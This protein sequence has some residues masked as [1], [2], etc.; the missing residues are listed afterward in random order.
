MTAVPTHPTPRVSVLIV[1][2]NSGDWL[3]RCLGALARQTIASFEAIVVDNASRDDSLGRARAAL[4]DPRISYDASPDN[5]GFAAGN[6]RAAAQARAPLLATLNPDAIPAPDWLERLLAAADANP[7]IAMFGSTQRAADDPTR[8]DG[9]GDAYFA[10]GLPWRAGFGRAARALPARFASF[11]PCAA[12]ALYRRA[13][14]EALGGFDARFFCYVEDVDLA[15]RWRLAGGRALQ[16]SDAVVDHAGGVSAGTAASGFAVYHGMRN[17]IWTFVKNM[18]GPL[19]WALLPG[20]LGLIALLLLRAA[21]QGQ[22]RP[23][24][25]GLAHAVAALPE[26]W[27]E[28]RRLQAGRRASAW[29]IAAAL[30]WAPWRL[31]DRMPPGIG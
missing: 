18:P 30:N 3:A 28:R 19:F 15:F 22:V 1:N 5:I 31:I 8:F 27:A 16:V 11:A 4:D 23:V 14:F 7:E 21:V 29:Q 13:G 6:N 20:H 26:I 2:F 17:L 10:L 24:G 12:A 25:R 9:I